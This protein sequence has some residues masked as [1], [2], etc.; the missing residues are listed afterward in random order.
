[1]AKIVEFLTVNVAVKDLDGAVKRY[2]DMGLTPLRPNRMPDPPAQITDVTVPLGAAGSI[3]LISPTDD[4][5]PVAPFLAKRGEG[6]YSV[7]VRV[8][9]LAGA[10]REWT[11][12]DWVLPEPAVFPEGT[13]ACHLLPDRL[14]ANWVKPRSLNGVMLEVFE[15][16]GEIREF[17]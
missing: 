17:K 2:A 11:H 6:M 16:Q 7:A 8:D 14:L 12:L 13:P 4:R 10:M 5:S 3:S 9:D 15:L 1:M